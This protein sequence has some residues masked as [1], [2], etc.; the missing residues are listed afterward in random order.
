MVTHPMECYSVIRRNEV[1]L[2]ADIDDLENFHSKSKKTDTESP[3]IFYG[4]FAGN[5]QNR[6]IQ[7]QSKLV[8]TRMWWW[9]NKEWCDCMGLGVSHSSGGGY[10]TL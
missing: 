1:L 2:H 3:V 7:T 6:Q 8:L 5:I 9:R 4:S 10:I